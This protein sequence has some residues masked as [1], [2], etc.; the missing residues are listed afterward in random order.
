MGGLQGFE[1]MC[2]TRQAHNGDG[3]LGSCAGVYRIV[4]SGDKLS[5]GKV[6]PVS[7][8]SNIFKVLGEGEEEGREAGLSRPPQG[9]QRLAATFQS[10]A[11]ALAKR[12]V[13]RQRHVEPY[14]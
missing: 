5:F 11:S 4:Y 1:I 13:R 8:T 12:F 3:G 14:F 10:A 9:W 6:Y 7:G 2:E